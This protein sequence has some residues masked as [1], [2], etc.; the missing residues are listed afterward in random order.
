MKL[1]ARKIVFGAVCYHTG[2]DEKPFASYMRAMLKKDE[3]TYKCITT[4]EVLTFDYTYEKPFIASAQLIP[5]AEIAPKTGFYVTEDAVLRIE[6]AY[7]Q[8]SDEH[9]EIDK[10]MNTLA[11]DNMIVKGYNAL[12]AYKERE[13]EAK[14]GNNKEERENN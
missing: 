1:D 13:K 14:K 3:N 7:H 12:V 4:G 6:T 11:F 9:I 2:D 5:M 8:K 10:W